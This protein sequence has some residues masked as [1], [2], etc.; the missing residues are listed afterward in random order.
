MAAD[1]EYPPID[2]YG[3]ISDMHS[4]ALV[5]KTGSIDWCCLPRFDSA[6]IFGRI[7]DWEKGGFF[8]I[9][10]RDTRSVKRRYIPGTN[11]LETT[12][13]TDTGVAT[14]TDFMPVGQTAHQAEQEGPTDQQTVH[15]GDQEDRP[16]QQLVR[17]LECTSGSVSFT[18]KCYPRF[19]YGS[20]VPHAYLSSSHTGFANG[21]AEAISFWCSNPLHQEDDG[22]W[23]EGELTAGQKLW[24]AIRYE[25]R[26]T[27][28]YI[29]TTHV[30]DRNEAELSKLLAE[31]I[32]FWQEW[33]S[34]CTY[35][36]KYHDAVLRSA[37]TLKA[38]TYAPS[39]GLV[40]AATTSLPEVIG[41]SRNWDYRF[42]WIRDASFALYGLFI[43]GY[44]AEARAFKGWLEWASAGRA[45]D[46]QLMYGLG[47]EKRLS[48]V[49][50]PGLM[51]Y[52]R[53]RPVRIGNAAY[54]Q[55]QLDVYGEIMD[56]AHLY[57]RYVGEFDTGYWEYLRRVVS[58]VIDHWREPDEGIWE[59][60]VGRQHFVFSK[61]WCWVALDR[62]I[63]AARALKLPG[64][65]DLWRRIRTEIRE[66]ILTNGFDTDRGAFVQA[67]GSKAL[68]A[69]NLMLPLV[70]FIKADDPRMLST[71]RAVESE[72]TS[73]QGFVYRYK[74]FDDG[75]GGVEGI[76]AICTF[77]LVD[78]L[79]LLGEI[80]RARQLF[81]KILSFTNDL[82][83]LSEEIDPESGQMLGN[84][85]QAFS[86]LGIINTA[87]HL[88]RAENKRANNKSGPKTASASK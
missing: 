72:L 49:E 39:G 43:L 22:Y 37:L 77:W 26:F 59:S 85:P 20:I 41:G 50:L 58:F 46:L 56:S 34:I 40:A 73:P 32:Q 44:T 4:C 21:G 61:V 36:G 23:S 53:S 48:E 75:L 64:D 55:F 66:D 57:R 9:T 6:S 15:R 8:E 83:L 67:Y 87:V 71:I 65:I 45:R 70:G 1:S 38:L 16:D 63:K 52:R 84:F 2:D 88:E 33:S 81:E 80:D 86:H 28:H 69:A 24:A 25:W 74:T 76:F 12:F 60:R 27:H 68:D 62:A 47:G 42:T 13:E 79:I 3:L 18:V 29:A 5:S 10:T 51:G 11:V 30:E 7:L 17:I 54:S 82:G 35:S 19:E 78:D 31:T 14:L